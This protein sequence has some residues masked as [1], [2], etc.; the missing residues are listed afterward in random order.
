VPRVRPIG[1]LPT[2]VRTRRRTDRHRRGKR[3]SR[4]SWFGHT[5][6]KEVKLREG[7]SRASR[8]SGAHF[9]Q[10]STD[11]YHSRSSVVNRK[12]RS[13]AEL[14][15]KRVGGRGVAKTYRAFRAYGARL[16][17]GAPESGDRNPRAATEGQS[18]PDRDFTPA[19]PESAL[20][21]IWRDSARARV[22]GHKSSR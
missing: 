3:E 17:A 20:C 6:G 4:S 2:V 12:R 22:A 11:E 10:R 18:F 13:F 1:A 19:S 5:W 7:D 16:G 15:L 8:R 9:R 21:T 14:L